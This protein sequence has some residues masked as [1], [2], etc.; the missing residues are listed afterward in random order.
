MPLPNILRTMMENRNANNLA[1]P[2]GQLSMA[3]KSSLP[4]S[5]SFKKKIIEDTPKHKV[6]IEHFEAI[7]KRC[8]NENESCSDEE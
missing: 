1:T 5:H 4:G 3:P 7:I 2:M 8:E 6:L